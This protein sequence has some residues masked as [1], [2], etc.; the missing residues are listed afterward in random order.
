MNFKQGLVLAM[1][2]EAAAATDELLIPETPADAVVPAADSA[3]TDMLEAA[4]TGTAVDA[5]LD[6]IDSTAADADS[7]EEIGAVVEDSIENGGMSETEVRSVEVA[8]ESI[9][10]RL[11]IKKS[12]MPAMESFKANKLAATKVAL[13]GIKEKL[14]SIW[15]AIVKAIERMTA[16]VKQFVMKLFDVN[17]KNTERAKKLNVA[18]A[19]LKDDAKKEDKV[20]GSFIATLSSGGKLDAVSLIETMKNTLAT[21]KA[22]PE[23]TKLGV[24]LVGK[25]GEAAGA[26]ADAGKFDAISFDV[27]PTGMTKVE[28]DVY[29]KPDEGMAYFRGK[30]LPGNRAILMLAP[31]TT[32]KGKALIDA[33]SKSK[34]MQ[35]NFDTKAAKTE[36]KEVFVLAPQNMASVVAAAQAASE[37]VTAGKASI[38][39]LEDARDK[40]V[41]EVKK[42]AAAP[43]AKD[44]G[45]RAKSLQRAAVAINNLTSGLVTVTAKTVVVTTK[46]ALDYVEKSMSKYSVPKEA[47]A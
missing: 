46:A 7:L 20:S 22:M 15:D 37:A 2:E 1:E 18:L 38:K 33:L 4:E 8:V 39:T 35:G 28:G 3:E 31:A 29:G 10:K 42:A 27:T 32:L 23:D 12:P 17:S 25:F 21:A 36:L 47:K 40:F 16:W 30:E 19:R 26:L 13:E 34:Y 9:Y 43:E 5:Q 24:E 6:A 41:A 45:D 11:G 14:K 44:S